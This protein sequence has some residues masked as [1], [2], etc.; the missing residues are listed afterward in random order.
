M[1]F[2]GNFGER[3]HVV[4]SL[5]RYFNIL[6]YGFLTN[7]MVSSFFVLLISFIGTRSLVKPW[8]LRNAPR[9]PTNS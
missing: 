7:L 1:G 9:V 3:I 8:S 6:A 5:G 4:C 2:F